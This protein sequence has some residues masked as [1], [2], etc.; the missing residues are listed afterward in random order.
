LK[1]AELSAAILVKANLTNANLVNVNLSDSDLTGATLRGADLSDTMLDKAIVQ[2]T[3]FRGAK[4]L[5]EKPSRKAK[6]YQLAYFDP[7][8]LGKLGLPADHNNRLM[9][10]NLSGCDFKIP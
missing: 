2:L 8:M 6:H 1:H 9:S 5:S 4:G 7:D 10:R 3:D